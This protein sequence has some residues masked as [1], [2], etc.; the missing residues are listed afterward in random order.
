MKQKIS[1]F[2]VGDMIDTTLV[3]T[4]ATARKT[5]AG[6]PF[7]VI[8]FFDGMEHIVGNYWDW[9]GTNIPSNN[10]VL[11]VKAQVT[12]YLGA[13]QL[14]VKSITTNSE[15]LLAEFAPKSDISIDDAFKKCW[16]LASD[17]NNDLLRQ[18]TWTVLEE[19]QNS[20]L[21]APGAKSVHHAYIGGTLVHSAS[22]ATIAKAI[23][24]EIP[25]ANIDLVV[26]G[27][28]LHDV[29]KLF[30]YKID[31]V[32]IDFTQNGILF[33]HLYL[34]ARYVEQVAFRLVESAADELSLFAACP[35]IQ[36]L[37]HIIVSHHGKQ[38]YGAIVPPECMEAH[39]VYHA[40]M[41]DAI[42]EQIRTESKNSNGIFTRKIWTLDNRMH[43]TPDYVLQ[44]MQRSDSDVE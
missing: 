34:G 22:V 15:V 2:I 29:G 20:W 33:D 30:T 35:L 31:G 42:R 37:I 9:G 28:I 41:L 11:N 7:L 17:I 32:N 38:E 10:A 18:L 13:K 16:E 19:Q 40:D 39:I 44:A 4:S 36:L 12:E 25:E 21:H 23:A 14:N 43:I 24:S 1:E 26:A 3:V 8:D 5:K 6:K 27:A